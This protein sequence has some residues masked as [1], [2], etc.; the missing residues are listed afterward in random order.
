MP[1]QTRLLALLVVALATACTEP[2]SLTGAGATFP[3]PLYSRWMSDYSAQKQ[4]QINYNSIGS[5]GGIKQIS[6]QTVDFGASD[7]P[8][9]DKE[10]AAAKGGAILHIPMVLGA[11]V[12]AYNLP[13]V[14]DT[15]K[16]DSDLIADIFLGKVTKWN[17]ARLAALN[18]GVKLPAADITTVH[19]S[20][21]SGTT[22]VFTDY[23]STVSTAWA[24]TSKGGPGKGK[25]VRWP[26]G[27]GG[28]GNEQVAGTVKQT[29]GAIGYIESVYALQN[30]AQVG[31]VKNKAGNFIAGN[32][33]SIMAAAAEAVAALGPETDY[34]V[35]IVDPPG[36][37]AYPIASF[38]W[39]LVYKQQTDAAKGRALVD[40]M[41]WAVTD[42]Q[43]QAGELHYG[44]LP[45][46]MRQ[47]LIKRIE[48][49]VL[50]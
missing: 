50:P 47:A 44:P 29:P 14:T 21:G 40:F 35:S 31:K 6:E 19:R 12:I 34:R 3:L 16:F 28:L 30:R 45:E 1:T 24:D 42:G 23:L 39:L 37:D 15:L 48:T 49:I 22:Y 41:K 11:V 32:Q 26:V 5:G 43:A 9:S 18:P 10:L 25:D 13:E 2:A 4:V 33:S 36:A 38:T 20:D 8:M 17:D 27:L 7:G 46:S